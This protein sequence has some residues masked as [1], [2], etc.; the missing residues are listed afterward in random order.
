[1]TRTANP[2]QRAYSQALLRCRDVA[3]KVANVEH[4]LEGLYTQFD[5]A[6]AALNVAHD[7]MEAAGLLMVQGDNMIR[8][9]GLDTPTRETTYERRKRY[10]PAFQDDEDET[11]D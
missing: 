11:T 7:A 3:T 5:E 4:Q 8:H 1:M 9:K 6:H 2:I 10:L